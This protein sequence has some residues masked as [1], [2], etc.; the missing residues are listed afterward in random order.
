M[1]HGTAAYLMARLPEVEI[2]KPGAPDSDD[3][4]DKGNEGASWLAGRDGSFW[5]IVV[6]IVLAALLVKA[7]KNP[8][9]RGILLG[10]VLLAIVGAILTK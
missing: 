1:L 10:V 9:V 3:I 2:P 4:I 5:T 8:L 6:V 7:L